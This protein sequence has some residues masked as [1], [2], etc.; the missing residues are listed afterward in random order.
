MNN[1][2]IGI[3]SLANP[4]PIE[5]TGIDATSNPLPV[6]IIGS[7]RTQFGEVKT[8]ARTPIIELNSSYGQSLLRDI[9][10]ET[11][12][13]TVADGSGEIVIS[14]GATASS[15]ARIKSADAGRYIPGYAAEVGTGVRFP[16][17]PTGNHEAQWGGRNVGET[18]GFFWGYDATGVYIARLDGGVV[19]GKVYQSSWNIDV[20]DGTGTS[21]ITLDMTAGNIFQIDFTWYGYGQ[22]V[23][24][25]VAVQG[26]SQEP[27]PVHQIKVA[28]AP[29]T[30]DP[31]LQV[32]GQVINGATASDFTG[33]VGGRQYSIVGRYRPSYRF[34]G[35][36][37]AAIATSTTSKPTVTFKSK[38]AFRSRSIKVDMMDII[39]A[40]KAVI[41]E[42]VINGSL[43][44]ASYA[45][46]TNHT[47]NETACEVDVSATAITG[48]VVIWSDY[49]AAGSGNKGLLAEAIVSLPIPEDQ[50]IS[51]CV[52]TTTGTGTCAAFFRMR[53]EW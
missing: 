14:T 16:T 30:E 46:P 9:V 40:T 29:S 36:Y 49:F 33:Y 8:A 4:L 42:L 3:D 15:V 6:E 51:L 5:I 39:P 18:D 27:V 32:F 1:S 41:V 50:P 13:G 7:E 10:T 2:S 34:S 21:G 19:L 37:R 35:E 43:T 22:I 53:E 28:G 11:N 25:I 52:R 12:T 24:N 45:N 23:W 47:A 48:G 38:T 26:R 20:A 44:G 17:A 31:N